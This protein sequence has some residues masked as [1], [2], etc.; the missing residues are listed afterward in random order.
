MNDIKEWI[1]EI[2]KESTSHLATPTRI[3]FDPPTTCACFN[4]TGEVIF[5][6]S[7][8]KI[9][10]RYTADSNVWETFEC[11]SRV[12]CLVLD[13]E[14]R[15]LA[16]GCF[17]GNIEVF[18][19]T[20]KIKLFTIGKAHSKSVKTIKFS[21]NGKY[22]LSGG[23]DAEMKLSS[24]EEKKVVIKSKEHE[25][26]VRSVDFY[27]PK[28]SVNLSGEVSFSTEFDRKAPKTNNFIVS[29]SSDNK[30]FLYKYSIGNEEKI[31]EIKK[32]LDILIHEEPVRGVAFDPFKFRILSGSKDKTMKMTAVYENE[33]H[34]L[35]KKELYKFNEA[36]SPVMSVCFTPDGRKVISG[37]KDKNMVIYDIVMI[38]FMNLRYSYFNHNKFGLFSF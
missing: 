26:S 22:L 15:L 17:N 2:K 19:I 24:I 14:D 18:S 16:A 37:C 10:A 33:E 32:V 9:V 4:R 20:K 3:Y 11:S 12:T 36:K 23:K 28:S 1:S 31:T 7:Q 6:A 25:K 21:N 5:H 35:E 29:G 38:N 8:N 30:I 34:Q 13:S 27:N